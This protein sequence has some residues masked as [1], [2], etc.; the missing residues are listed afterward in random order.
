[1]GTLNHCNICWRDNTAEHKQSRMFLE[2]IDDNFLL[3]VTEETK[4]RGV[5]LD[6]ILTDKEGLTGIVKLKGS[7]G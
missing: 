2:C 4:R 3:Q 5:K 7:L 6:F 1:M